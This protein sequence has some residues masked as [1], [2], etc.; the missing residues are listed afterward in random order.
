MRGLSIILLAVLCI[1]IAATIHAISNGSINGMVMSANNNAVPDAKVTLWAI[2][3]ENNFAV[4]SIE[5]NPQYTTNF[6]N[7][8][9]GVYTFFD[10]P[11][12]VYNITAEKDNNSFFAIAEVK[13]GTTTA[14][15]VLPGFYATFEPPAPAIPE[16]KEYFT[17]VP[18]YIKDEPALPEGI[19]SPGLTAISAII[20]MLI[21]LLIGAKKILER[22]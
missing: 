20:S 12:G 9:V 11:P 15:I 21:A 22:S 8:M 4:M 18:V 16:R 19:K 6:S 13:E 5:D 17:Y 3:G 7:S 1:L 2:S 14:N 10:V